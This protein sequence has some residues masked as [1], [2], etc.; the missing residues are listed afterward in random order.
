M[1]LPNQQEIENLKNPPKQ[2]IN[3]RELLTFLKYQNIPQRPLFRALGSQTVGVVQ[4]AIPHGI[5][6]TPN[7]VIIQMTSPGN[8]YQSQAADNTNI[9]LTSDHYLSRS[10]NVEVA[11]I[12]DNLK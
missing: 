7:V 11:L 3:L 9:Y 10:C 4:V 2:P 12:Q 6:G 8:V 1:P 5:N